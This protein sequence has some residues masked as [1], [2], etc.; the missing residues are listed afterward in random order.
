MVP[1][2]LDI[3]VQRPCNPRK[4]LA[5]GP[6]PSVTGGFGLIIKGTCFGSVALTIT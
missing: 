2:T 6:A 5:P 1:A 4:E 3:D